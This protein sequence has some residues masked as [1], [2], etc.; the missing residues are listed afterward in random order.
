MAIVRKV[1]A[2][3]TV[4]LP[5]VIGARSSTRLPGTTPRSAAIRLRFD[6]SAPAAEQLSIGPVAR[7]RVQG[8]ARAVP[9]GDR[10]VQHGDAAVQALRIVQLRKIENELRHSAAGGNRVRVNRS[11]CAVY[12]FVLLAGN[13]TLPVDLRGHHPYQR[14]AENCLAGGAC[15]VVCKRVISKMGTSG[16]RRSTATRMASQSVCPP[17]HVV[18]S[19]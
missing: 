12:S 10:I 1:T 7:I 6:S 8:D 5:S 3:P 9:F 15:P 19:Y 14:S 13:I 17:S 11:T 2:D 18:G 4:P 16:R